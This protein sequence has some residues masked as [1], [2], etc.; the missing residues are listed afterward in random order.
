M[1]FRS[2]GTLYGLSSTGDLYTINTGTAQST[3]VA[4]LDVDTGVTGSI[5]FSP[6]GTLIGSGFGG[7]SGDI[8]FDIDPANGAVSNI[9]N[10]PG[11]PQGM[12]FIIS[13]IP[14]PATVALTALALTALGGY[15]R[16]RRRT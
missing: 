13:D 14:E 12:G 5:V 10:T 9:R 1:D 11:A 3:F 15:V 4:S 16:R 7:P 8:L 2:D 6:E